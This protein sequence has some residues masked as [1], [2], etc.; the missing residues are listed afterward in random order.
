MDFQITATCGAARAGAI[1][2]ARGEVRTPA[3]MPVGT[4]GAVKG[5]SPSE[6][7]ALGFD[8]MLANAFHLWLRPGEDIVAAHGG[9]HG[10]AGWRRPILTDSGGY[11]IFSLRKKRT[12]SEEGALFSAPHSGE[13]RLLTPEICIRIQRDLASDIAMVLDDCPSP[14]NSKDEIRRSMELSMRWARRGKIAHGDSPAALFGIVQGGVYEDLRAESADALVGI[15]FDGYAVGGLAVGESKDMLAATVAATAEK[16]PREKPRY[17]MGVG[18]PADIARAV[19]RGIDMMDCVLPS[20]NARNGHLFTG[21]GVLRIR[22]A[23]HRRDTAPLDPACDCPAC[24]T[25]SRAC[26]HHLLAANEMLAAR[27]MTI[28]NL[29]HYRR[30]MKTLRQA[31]QDGTLPAAVRR[32]EMLEGKN[33]D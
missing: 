13:K 24:R 17:L 23:R 8:M 14:Q 21:G 7:A 28:H 18:A 2:T 32:V 6:L 9:L 29:A 33:A 22:N 10:F 11:Q 26:L 25:F 3:F 12:L 27:Y 16:L 4:R 1:R 20:R 15:G 19:L 31:I 30:L 5:V